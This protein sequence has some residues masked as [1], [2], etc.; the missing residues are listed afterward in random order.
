MEALVH[1]AHSQRQQL[2]QIFPLAHSY[3]QEEVMIYLFHP[4]FTHIHVHISKTSR[5]RYDVITCPTQ[6]AFTY[7][8]NLRLSLFIGPLQPIRTFPLHKYWNFRSNVWSTY[9]IYLH[10][11]HMH[12]HDSDSPRAASIEVQ[13]LLS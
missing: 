12:S 1:V 13:C 5:D 6:K 8:P 10:V 7:F 9:F 11:V 4:T 3:H 2:Q